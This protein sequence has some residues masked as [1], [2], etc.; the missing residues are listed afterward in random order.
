ME[1][2][3]LQLLERIVMWILWKSCPIGDF[4]IANHAVT[5]LKT[6]MELQFF[7]VKKMVF[8][9]FKCQIV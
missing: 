5:L 6:I 3:A 7:S 9:F 4:S 8:P 2:V 1:A